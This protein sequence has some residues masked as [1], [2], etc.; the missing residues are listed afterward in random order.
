MINITDISLWYYLLALLTVGTALGV[1]FLSDRRT[2]RQTL[3]VLGILVIELAGAALLVWALA[4][5][6]AW[7]SIAIIVLIF[8]GAHVTR[9]VR[10]GIQTYQRSRIHTHEHYEYLIGN[11]ASRLEALM[12]SVRRALR[13][14]VVKTLH[15]WS[16]VLTS[17]PLLLLLGLLIA[18]AQPAAAAII[19]LL[20]ALTFLGLSV[21]ITIACI[22]IIENY[23]TK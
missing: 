20:A 16:R 4:K 22:W 2:M 18:G 9:A 15:D 12:P 11:G 17:A 1:F 13:A 6:S 10:K 14:S 8:G 7:W 23:L 5:A 21:L 19:A 3:K